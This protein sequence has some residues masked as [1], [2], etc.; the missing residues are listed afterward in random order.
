M[1]EISKNVNEFIDLIDTFETNNNPFQSK[2]FYTTFFEKY[3]RFKY[4]ILKVYDNTN[5]LVGLVPL[6]EMLCL[7]G[8]VYFNFI[9]YRKGNY[10]GY[11]CRD[12]QEKLVHFEVRNYFEN[13]KKACIINYYDINN[14]NP[15][16][17]I[18]LNDKSVNY[19]IELYK[20]PLVSLDRDP[21]NFF[22]SKI[23]N[24]KKRTEIRKFERKLGLVG[25]IKMIQI[26]DEASYEEYEKFLEQIYYIHKERFE[27]VYTPSH[28]SDIKYRYYYNNMIERMTKA[29]KAFISLLLIDDV[30]ISFIFCLSNQKILID[31]IPAFD[32][33]FTKYNLGTVHYK[34]LFEY[35]CNKTKYEYFDFSKGE[36]VYKLRWA[37]RE[38]INY[39]FVIVYNPNII[40]SMFNIFN[41]T[42]FKFKAY[43]RDIGVLKKIKL[44]MG[45]FIKENTGDKIQKCNL[46]IEKINIDKVSTNFKMNYRRIR[47][48]D[49]SHRKEILDALY[50]G[51]SIEI[52]HADSKK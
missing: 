1:I 2:E 32:P 15:L 43:L 26:C 28:F 8:L 31:W 23:T 16:Y 34:M 40:S 22:R 35:L 24:S 7:P 13:S 12:D 9:G 4:L 30:V 46:I 29:N 14:T 19:M 38:T 45:S 41:T 33:A 37:D 50:E 48:C 11:I 36:S 44:R 20:C 39:Q 52:I 47:F 51:K 18:L 27:K 10:L 42:K 5:V 6:R 3:R 21:E 49:I 17:Q 25:K